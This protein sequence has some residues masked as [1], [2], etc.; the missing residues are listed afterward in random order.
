MAL[1]WH[2]TVYIQKLLANGR[3]KFLKTIK[4]PQEVNEMAWD[5]SAQLFFLTTGSGTIEVQPTF[6]IE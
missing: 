6:S 2:L 4:F 5:P 3:A 1:S